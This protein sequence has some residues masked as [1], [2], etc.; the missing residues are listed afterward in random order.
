MSAKVL[1]QT[2]SDRSE[3]LRLAMNFLHGADGETGAVPSAQRREHEAGQT[4]RPESELG[5]CD[6]EMTLEN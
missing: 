6:S 4:A 2:G 3:K 1:W 5:V